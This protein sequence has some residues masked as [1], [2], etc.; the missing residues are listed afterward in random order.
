MKECNKVY[1]IKSP[2]KIG[3]FIYTNVSWNGWYLRKKD[4]PYKIKV[5]FIGINGKENFF[6]VVYEK[7]GNMLS[8]KFSEIGERVFLSYDEA[9]KNIKS[10]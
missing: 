5:V 7:N 9:L 1:L 4:R 6:N 3:D 10:E 2:V 8:F